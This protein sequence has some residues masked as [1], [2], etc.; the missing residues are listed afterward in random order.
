[1]SIRWH[2]MSRSPSSNTPNRPAGPA[3]T[4]ATSVSKLSV[5]MSALLGRGRHHEPVEIGRDLDLAGQSRSRPHFEG[6]VEHVLLHLRG[7]A[8]DSGPGV[9][10]IDMAGRAGAGAAAFGL[11]AGDGVANRRLHHRRAVLGLHG[12]RRAGRV[13]VG[14]FRHRCSYCPA[15]P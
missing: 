14:D 9:V 6:E 12:A 13:L 7:L 11:D 2:L 15:V 3:P 5:M 8:D 1:M 10:D 4:M